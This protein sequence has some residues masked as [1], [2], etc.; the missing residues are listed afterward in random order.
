MG[1]TKNH[2][3]GQPLFRDNPIRGKP[4][5]KGNLKFR[6]QT[7]FGGQQ[8]FRDQTYF[9]GFSSQNELSCKAARK[10]KK[11]PELSERKT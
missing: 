2:F 1:T 9:K 6:G 3:R 8:Y 11:I 10:K 7:H 5:F 4:H